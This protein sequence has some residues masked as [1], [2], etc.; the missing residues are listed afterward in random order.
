MDIIRTPTPEEMDVS[1]PDMDGDTTGFHPIG[2]GLPTKEELFEKKLCEEQQK[3]QKKG[4][5]FC[6]QVARQDFNKFYKQREEYLKANGYIDP[7]NPPEFFKKDFPDLDWNK[8]S[9]LKNFELVDEKDVLDTYLTEKNPGLEVMMK[10]KVYRFKGYTYTF[11]V[12][13]T[14]TSAIIRARQ[15]LKDLERD[16]PEKKK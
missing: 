14:G 3:A 6:H 12:M 10:T 16:T 1:H 8:Y 7:R 13:E 9:D 11:S 15:K 5:P 2:Y 4:L